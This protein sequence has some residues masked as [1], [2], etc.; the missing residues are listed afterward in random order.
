MSTVTVVNPATEQEVACYAEHS[1]EQIEAAIAAADAAFR[2]WRRRPVEERARAADAPS[3]Q[4]LRE[5]ADELARLITSEMGKPLAEAAAEVEKC[6]WTLR[7]LRR[8][9]PRHSSPTRADRHER[10]GRSYVATSRSA[11]CSRSCRG[12]S[13]SGRSSASP[14]RR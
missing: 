7:L 2:E 3:R 13:R 14:R 1:A 9:A 8:D 5:R 6:A 12:T 11:S 10:R 4:V